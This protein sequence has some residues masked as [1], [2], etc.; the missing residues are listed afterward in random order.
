[1][2]KSDL[3][4]LCSIFWYIIII[5]TICFAFMI[6]TL[7]QQWEIVSQV[8]RI[9]ST[10]PE[11]CSSVSISQIDDLISNKLQEQKESITRIIENEIYDSQYNIATSVREV[12]AARVYCSRKFSPIKQPLLFD[13]CV[14]TLY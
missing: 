1:M 8:N 5:L 6:R 13:S 14:E 3:Q 9:A 12:K 2:T 11:S 10:M 7:S 4:R